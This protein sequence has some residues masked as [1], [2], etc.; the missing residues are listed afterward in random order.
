V[1]LLLLALI[2]AFL[3][4][5][6]PIW[7]EAQK[8]WKTYTVESEFSFKY[9]SNWKLEE[10]ENRFT[11]MDARLEYGNNDVQMTFEGMSPTDA[12]SASDIVGRTDSELLDA[13]ET[14]IDDKNL[15]SVFESGLDKYT[16]NNRTA[17]YAIGTYST[18]S[19]FGISLE[20][21]VMMTAVHVGDEL[22]LIQYLA[23]EDD[24][25]KHLPKVEQV[26]NS[27]TPAEEAQ[28][29]PLT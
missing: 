27:I 14:V 17:P 10:R 25:D 4:G 6:S 3:F 12:G 11:S 16:I 13:L 29:S 15:G 2:V 26:L 24:F 20:M 9:P 23:E 18:E 19:L 8:G 21:A 1:K 7:V 28:Q 5:F 22:V